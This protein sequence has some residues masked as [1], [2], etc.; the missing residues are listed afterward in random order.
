MIHIVLV[1]PQIPPNTGN[2]IRLCANTGAKLHLIEPL[3]FKLSDKHMRRAGLDYNEFAD[4]QSYTDW[5][6]FR[7]KQGKNRMWL[8]SSKAKT[9][10]STASFQE[11]DML[12]FGNETQGVSSEIHTELRSH[13]LRIPMQPNSRCLNL[14]NSVAIVLYA[15]LHSL[16]FVGLT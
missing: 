15:A 10:Y 2:I 4:I 8:I 6:D 14:S 9:S 5:A 16:N 13:Q 12:V 11:N 7:L 3:G 1:K